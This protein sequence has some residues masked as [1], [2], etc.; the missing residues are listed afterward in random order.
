MSTACHRP[1]SSDTG[2]NAADGGEGRR[3]RGHR[4]LGGKHS[5]ETLEGPTPESQ[6]SRYRRSPVM[7][8]LSSLEDQLWLQMMSQ[9]RDGDAHIS[10][11]LASR[12]LTAIKTSR[13]FRLNSL[14]IVQIHIS[15]L[16]EMKG[17]FFSFLD[18][19]FNKN[20]TTIYNHS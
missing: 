6:L 20:I 13:W 19:L 2:L 1:C 15:R 7:K 12:E 14:F 5:V 10:Q 16:G 4:S 11:T 3:R 8:T 18:I 17:L 9:M